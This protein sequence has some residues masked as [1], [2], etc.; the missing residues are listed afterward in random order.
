VGATEVAEDRK[1]LRRTLR[2]FEQFE[3]NC[4]TARIIFPWL[5]TPAHLARLALGTMLYM[6]FSRLIKTRKKTG[7]RESDAVQYLLDQE[8]GVE[9]I[10]RVSLISIVL[11]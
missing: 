6:D 11:E 4:S 7:K 8:G 1:L 5:L 10:I 9:L 2:I 3:K